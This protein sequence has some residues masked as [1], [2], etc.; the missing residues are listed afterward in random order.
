MVWPMLLGK[1]RERAGDVPQS[2]RP[3]VSRDGADAISEVERW[4]EVQESRDGWHQIRTGAGEVG[5]VDGEEVGLSGLC[6]PPPP[7]AAV[8]VPLIPDPGAP[9]SSVCVPSHPGP[10]APPANVHLG[11]AEQYAVIARPGNWA[12]VLKRSA[13]WHM[14]WIGPGDVGWVEG[15]RVILSGPYAAPPPG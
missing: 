15:E 6:A 8:D 10:G 13:G 4:A 1:A 12:E 5:W 2:A 11:P 7:T 9:P 3:D 14:I